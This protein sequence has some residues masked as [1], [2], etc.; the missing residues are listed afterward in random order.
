MS[1][2]DLVFDLV[3]KSR[4][5]T[6]GLLDQIDSDD[7]F[8]QPS[9]GV[10]HVAW[11]VGHLAVAEYRLALERVRGIQPADADLIP[12]SFSELFG[13]GSVPVADSAKYP[14]P[15]EIKTVFDQIHQRVLDETKSLAES[16]LDESIE[17]VHPMFST[18]Y[19]ALVWCAQHELTHAGQITL[20]RRLFGAA[21]LR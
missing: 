18:K 10:T 15:A 11:Q 1:R 5:Y 16:V 17:P 8:R 14:S 3:S 7:W 19:G 6:L 9:E 20:L 2:V 12:A 13:K 4:G 21:P